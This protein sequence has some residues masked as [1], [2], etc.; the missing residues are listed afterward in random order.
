MS[1]LLVTGRYFSSGHVRPGDN[2][3][4]FEDIGS[5]GLG[6][7]KAAYLCVYVYKEESA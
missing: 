7:V 5:R 2:A 6:E 3:R 1:K 4:T